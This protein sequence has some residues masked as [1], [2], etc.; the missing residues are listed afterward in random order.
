MRLIAKGLLFHHWQV[1]V[2]KDQV[3]HAQFMNEFG[4]SN[5]TDVIT[6]LQTMAESFSS[7][8]VVRT[9][10]LIHLGKQAVT[11]EGFFTP[12]DRLMSMRPP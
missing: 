10:G 4:A 8:E 6:K 12:I 5:F 9:T 11:Y 3:V 2:P 7:L 1:I